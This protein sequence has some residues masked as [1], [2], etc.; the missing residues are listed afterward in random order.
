MDVNLHLEGETANYIEALVKRGLAANKTEAIRL[1]IVR[2]MEREPEGEAGRFSQA[3]IEKAWNGPK[4]KEAGNFYR[5]RYLR[6]KK[7]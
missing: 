6:G 3:I 4:D 1:S 2:S 5:Q 7:A